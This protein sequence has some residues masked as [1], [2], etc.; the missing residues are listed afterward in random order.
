MSSI[1]DVAKEAGVSPA[2]VSRTFRDP[3]LLSHQTRRRVLEVANRLD[4]RPRRSRSSQSSAPARASAAFHHA[5]ALGF[6]FFALES[7]AID[8]S[9][10]YS[11][12]LLGAQAEAA[13]NGMHLVVDNVSRLRPSEALPK[14]LRENAVAG[15]LLV[16]AAPVD[17]LA[18]LEGL[19]PLVLVDNKDQ[20]RRCDT[21]MS[22]GFGGAFEA[23][24]HLLKL[25]HRRIGFVSNEPSAPSFQD[26]YRG[27]LSALFDA[28]ISPDRDWIVC[29]QPGQA[30]DAA[31]QAAL[32]GENRPTAIVAAN[33]VNALHAMK[34]CREAGLEIPSD[35]S[36]VG[37]DDIPSAVHTSPSLTTIRV[38]KE[39][40]G[41]LAVR[42]LRNRIREKDDGSVPGLP[43]HM[44]VPTNLIVRDSCRSMNQN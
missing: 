20:H 41:R 12:I 19:L 10:C 40:I 37:F 13:K 15:A 21:I 42:C 11:P 3:S 38:D 29:T 22:D 6:L 14:M 16:G 2:T 25:G 23:T 34:A 27:Y 18:P 5:D 24:H 4:Y 7:D 35:L 36:V 8:I 1:T 9:E 30:M 39:Y 31:L 43:V 28:G 17:V 44:S 32:H 26:R 33:D